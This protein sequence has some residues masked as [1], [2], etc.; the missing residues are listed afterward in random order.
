VAFY[1]ITSGNSV[2]T[3]F[4]CQVLGANAV[5]LNFRLSPGE[6]ACI[7][8][9]SGARVMVYG[10]PLTG[11]VLKIAASVRSVH[12]YVS[13]ATDTAGVPEGHGHFETLAE[14]TPDRAEPRPVPDG[15]DV[16][17]LVYTPGTTGRPKGV[18]H[19]YANDV[20]IAMNCVMECGLEKRDVALHIAPLYHVGGVQAL[21]AA[22]AGGGLQR[23]A[24]PLRGR[25]DAGGHRRRADHDAVRR[26]HADPGD[27]VPPPPRT[28]SP[29]CGWRRRGAR[30]S[31]A[32]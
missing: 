10:R 26:A 31:R 12:D 28:A 24:G 25:E 15:R 18:V 4:A 5:P 29:R 8:K 6:A 32:R 27:A 3:S 23:R 21:P 14:G 30:P 7:L 20:A 17:A 2:A 1:V 13:C 11:N 22:P 16:S 9:D 19:T